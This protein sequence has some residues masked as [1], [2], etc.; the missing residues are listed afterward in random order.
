MS[1]PYSDFAWAG[2]Y[3]SHAV[4]RLRMARASYVGSALPKGIKAA[5]LAALDAKID[6]L[7]AVKLDDKAY[8]WAEDGVLR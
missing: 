7:E 2:S 8:P 4:R 1:A 6:A 3:V 5:R